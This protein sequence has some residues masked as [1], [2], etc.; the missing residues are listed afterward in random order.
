MHRTTR[1]L[2]SSAQKVNPFLWWRENVIKPIHNA[3][4]PLPTIFGVHASTYMQFIYPLPVWIGGYFVMNWAMKESE[5]NIGEG[6]E[7]LRARRDL[8]HP[9]QRKQNEGLQAIIDKSV[10][11]T[12]GYRSTRLLREE[13]V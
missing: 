4:I 2:L 5:K 7:K 6:G 13:R 10:G 11:T 8:A 12:N 3:R 1:I 9:N